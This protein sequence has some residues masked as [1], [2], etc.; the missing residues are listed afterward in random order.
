MNK[1]TVFP[2]TGSDSSEQF[3]LVVIQWCESVTSRLLSR[4][5]A[6]HAGPCCK[7]SP[8][9]TT[10]HRSTP[11]SVNYNILPRGGQSP[12][13][14][15]LLSQENKLWCLFCMWEEKQHLHKAREM[16][17]WTVCSWGFQGVPKIQLDDAGV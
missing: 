10:P 15:N 12:S 9:P 14:A 17:R 16:Q 13:L 5:C 4:P 3:H 6:K 7:G 1:E 2:F 11:C 8:S